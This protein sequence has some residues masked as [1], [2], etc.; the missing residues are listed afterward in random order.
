M[1]FGYT[2]N[3]IQFSCVFLVCCLYDTDVLALQ[4]FII[5]APWSVWFSQRIKN[6]VLVY[7]CKGPAQRQN[8][9]AFVEWMILFTHFH[10]GEHRNILEKYNHQTLALRK[11]E[12]DLIA[13]RKQGHLAGTRRPLNNDVHT[14]G[15][16]RLKETGIPVAFVGPHLSLWSSRQTRAADGT[17]CLQH[18]PCI[19]CVSTEIS[20]AL[21]AA[22]CR[23]LGHL[24]Q[25]RNLISAGAVPLPG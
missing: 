17:R 15:S 13:H 8:Q 16:L 24:Y 23:L 20:L 6:C 22:V 12:T 25:P 14:P 1:A 18:G 10:G 19:K 9:S 21:H 11:D 5:C 2:V 3:F 7:L 4:I